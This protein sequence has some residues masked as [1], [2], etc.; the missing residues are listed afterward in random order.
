MAGAAGLHSRRRRSKR[1]ACWPGLHA[2]WRRF[3][4]PRRGY[5]PKAHILL[6]PPSSPLFRL[7]QPTR[8]TARRP[9]A[10]APA[11]KLTPGQVLLTS[12]TASR[13]SFG[14]ARMPWEPQALAERVRE[15]GALELRKAVRTARVLEPRRPE[16]QAERSHEAVEN[17]VLQEGVHPFAPRR[18]AKP[19]ISAPSPPLG[20]PAWIAAVGRR[21]GRM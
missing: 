16:Q 19:R 14:D 5:S 15:T 9:E 6:E 21:A 17:D 10:R 20:S 11:M 1:A 13:K 2:A 7:A 3:G 12:A 4:R 18:K 8:P